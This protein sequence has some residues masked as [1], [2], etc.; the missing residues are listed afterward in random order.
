MERHKGDRKK[1][2]GVSPETLESSVQSRIARRAYE[3][4]LERGGVSGNEID[5]WLQAEHEIQQDKH[6]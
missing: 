3:L 6:H 2:N 4:Y 5:D 1:E